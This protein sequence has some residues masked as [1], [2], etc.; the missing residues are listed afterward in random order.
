MQLRAESEELRAQSS[1]Q[2]C[3]LLDLKSKFTVWL[4][5][6]WRV[7]LSALDSQLSN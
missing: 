6:L 7:L 4:A 3:S 1:E 2:T 5:R